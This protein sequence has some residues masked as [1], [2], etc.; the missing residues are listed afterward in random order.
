LASKALEL[1]KSGLSYQSMPPADRWRA[2]AR[3]TAL[4]ILAW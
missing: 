3:R 4:S 2:G 1:E